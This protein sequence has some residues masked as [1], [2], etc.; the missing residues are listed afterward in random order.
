MPDQRFPPEHHIR[1][2]SDFKRTY[3]RRCSAGDRTLLVFGF[4]NG[5]QHARLGLSVSRKVGGAVQRNR[6]KRLLREAFR[7]ERP[8]L[9]PGVDLVVIPRQGVLP[10]LAILRQSLT[11]LAL[12]VARKLAR[13]EQSGGP[14]PASPR[15]T[16]QQTQT[17][18]R[19]QAGQQTQ[20]GQQGK[21]GHGLQ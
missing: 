5:L 12:T 10:A 3:E 7:L 13:S 4:R 19:V 15:L 6:W 17:G 11:V 1:R 2:P 9:P 20:V 16:G 18:Q 14:R 8:Q 21:A